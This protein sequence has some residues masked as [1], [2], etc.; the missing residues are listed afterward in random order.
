MNNFIKKAYGYPFMVLAL[1]IAGTI[2][3]G[4][5][6]SKTC[7]HEVTYK[8]TVLSHHTTSDK[9]GDIEYYTVARFEDGRIRSMSG[10]NFYVKPVGSTI[11]YTQTKLKK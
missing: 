7:T 1:L 9:D 4:V 6:F 11:H 10:L 3:I 2:L 5:I 8:G